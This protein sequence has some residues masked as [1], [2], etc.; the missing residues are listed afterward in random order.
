[1]IQMVILIE[2]SNIQ[3]LGGDDKLGDDSVWKTET[4][5]KDRHWNRGITLT[6]RN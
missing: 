2:R 4:R 1:M 6:L 5:E 3:I